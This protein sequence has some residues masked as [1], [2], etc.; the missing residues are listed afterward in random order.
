MSDDNQYQDFAAKNSVDLCK[1]KA[2]EIQPPAPIGKIKPHPLL[3]KIK[4]IVDNEKSMKQMP[5]RSTIA[6]HIDGR[7][8]ALNQLEDRAR[9]D[10]TLHCYVMEKYNGGAFIDGAKIHGFFYMADYKLRE[11]QP[12]D[13]DMRSNEA[14]ATWCESQPDKEDLLENLQPI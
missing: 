8:D 1:K 13:A 2:L 4:K 10:E 11:P 6:K 5:P 12:T 14:W 7:F 9:A 3:A